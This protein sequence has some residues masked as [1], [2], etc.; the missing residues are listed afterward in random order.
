LRSEV[1]LCHA[2]APCGTGGA[3]WYS[4]RSAVGLQLPSLFFQGKVLAS[5][6]A[7][8]AHGLGDQAAP[9]MLEQGQ[10]LITQLV[11]ARQAKD[12]A[13]RLAARDRSG[14]FDEVSDALPLVPLTSDGRSSILPA[15][16]AITKTQ[17]THA[18]V[19]TGDV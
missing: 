2:R 18:A 14:C 4:Y 6:L 13:E 12:H 19:W 3:D 8:S 5:P 9:Q 10:L 11:R 16:K 1:R 15:G 7:L 17:R